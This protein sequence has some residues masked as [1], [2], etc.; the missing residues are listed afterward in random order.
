[1]ACW[2]VIKYDANIEQHDGREMNDSWIDME[3]I[4]DTGKDMYLL[5]SYE[6]LVSIGMVFGIDPGIGTV[7]YFDM[8]RFIR[9]IA[10][11]DHMAAIL[12]IC[13]IIS[14]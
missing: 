3:G 5:L 9:L 10:V 4:C 7:G 2:E 1:M 11:Y 13:Y 6:C 14:I 12:W 8:Y